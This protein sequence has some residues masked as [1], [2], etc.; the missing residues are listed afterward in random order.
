MHGLSTIVALNKR[1]QKK[2]DDAQ[3]DKAEINRLRAALRIA[4]R[5]LAEAKT[6]DWERSK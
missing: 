3:K 5:E 2:F 1:A 6:I 4:K